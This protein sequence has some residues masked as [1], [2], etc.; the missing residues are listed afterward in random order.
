MPPHVAS[1]KDRKELTTKAS[2][3]YARE[4]RKGVSAGRYHTTW[5]PDKGD[6]SRP[7]GGGRKR[8]GGGEPFV[9]VIYK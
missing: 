7:G 1:R 5:G 3:L 2:S 8:K 6:R 4:N 9:G